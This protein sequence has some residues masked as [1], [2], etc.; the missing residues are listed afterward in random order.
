MEYKTVDFEKMNTIIIEDLTKKYFDSF[1]KKNIKELEKM[2]SDNILLHDWSGVWRG[3]QQVL[4]MNKEL[5]E[6]VE[7]IKVDVLNTKAFHIS[8]R[9]E[10]KSMWRVYCHIYI[11]TSND[12]DLN[13]T[14]DVM[15]VIDWGYNEKP[16]I[17]KIK[18][19]KCNK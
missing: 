13:T 6:G 8:L 16:K 5:F 18:A 7:L 2:Y 10:R 14:L 19:Y 15:D 4:D 3:K 17:L 1:S 11:K 9:E 12:K